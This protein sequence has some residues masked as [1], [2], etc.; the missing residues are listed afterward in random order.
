MIK[1]FSLHTLERAINRALALDEASSANLAKLDGKALKIII[2]P[3]KAA[4]YLSF[5]QG[6]M[7]VQAQAPDVVHTTIESSPLGLIKLSFLPASRTRSLFNNTIT[8]SGD[9]LLGEQVKRL[10]DE[11]DIDWESHLAYF[12]GDIAAYHLGNLV[13]KG[14]SFRKQVSHTLQQTIT[15]YVQEE[16]LLTPPREAVEDFFSDIAAL[17]NDVARLEAHFKR[18]TSL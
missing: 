12:T 8:I 1:K 15:E 5:T 16:V 14:Q 17:Q 3:L 7:Q 6:Q 13:R 2:L 4:F 10:F 11:L 18:I 9:V